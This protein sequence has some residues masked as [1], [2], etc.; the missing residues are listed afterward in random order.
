[1]KNLFRRLN[2]RKGFTL[3][4]CLI[5]IAVF[6]ALTMVVFAILTNARNS[7]YLPVFRVLI[8][9]ISAVF[10]CPSPL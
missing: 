6:A 4:E 9:L 5:A 2:G 7:F 8:Y 1:M 10:Y 3:V